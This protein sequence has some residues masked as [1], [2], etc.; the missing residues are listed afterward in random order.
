[1]IPI[2]FIKNL[3]KRLP[4]VFLIFVLIAIF[5]IDRSQL[6]YERDGMIQ[7]YEI[8][9]N[10]Y[11]SLLHVKRQSVDSPIVPTLKH[12]YNDSSID[13][14]YSIENVSLVG[15]LPS[16]IILKEMADFNTKVFDAF[17]SNMCNFIG[18][19]GGMAVKP[20]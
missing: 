8:K 4:F 17:E 7:L 1:M 14:P 3:A 10:L 16:K 19:Y 9:K 6:I 15:S 18:P 11:I 12:F 2:P 13:D 5:L 20:C